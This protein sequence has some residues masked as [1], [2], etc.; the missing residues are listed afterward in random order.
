MLTAEKET[1]QATIAHNCCTLP[2]GGSTVALIL[3]IKLDKESK[4]DLSI[5][6]I[7]IY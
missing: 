1:D 4:I 5:N 7:C 3:G 2:F 6:L